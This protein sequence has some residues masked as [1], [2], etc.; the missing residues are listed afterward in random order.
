MKNILI[1]TKKELRS[2]FNNPTA[3]VVV[4]AFLLLWEFLFFRNVFLIG[5]VSLDELFQYLPW[6]FMVVVS[7]LTM[8]TFSEEKKEG[9]LEF[10]LTHPV[11]RAE[12][13]IGKFL[14]IIAFEAAALLFVFP[15]AWSFSLFGELDWGKV[16]GQYL[17][18][19]FIGSVLTS[20]GIF[21]ST[22]FLSQISSFLVSLIGGFF[23]IIVGTNFFSSHFPLEITPF[24]EQL[25]ALNHFNSISRGVVDAR[26]VWYFISLTAVFL[27][28][29]YL[30]LIKEK[31]GNRKSAYINYQVGLI[32]M[33]G[34]FVLSNV[35]G[36][37]I[38]GRIDL[39]KEKIYTL[40]SVTKDIVSNL[41]DLVN[42]SLYASDKLPAQ[43]QPV[44]RETKNILDDYRRFSKG[45]IKIYY[46]NPSADNEIAK[47]AISQGIQPVRFNVVS[48]EEFQVKDGYLGL[49]VSYG[50]RSE[51]I[52]FVEN[53]NDLEYQL[54]SLIYKLTIENKPKIGLVS[55]HGEKSFYGDYRVINDELKKQFETV[56]VMAKGEEKKNEEGKSSGKSDDSDKAVKKI[57][58]PDD[59]K[60]LIIAN[61]SQDYSDEER[62]TISQFI[63]KGGNV[64]FLLD[65]VSVLPQVL[66]ASENQNNLFDFVKSQ[67]GVEVEKNL[68]YDLR[69]NESVS[70]GDGQMRYILPYPFWLRAL[71]ATDNSPIVSKIDSVTLPWASSLN[72]DKKAADE[73]GFDVTELLSTTQYAGTQSSIFDITPD[74]KLSSENLG[75]KVLAVALASRQNGGKIII[76]GDADFLDSENVKNNPSNFS[77][78]VEAVSWLGQ[79][80]RL[81]Q[82]K[83]K[84]LSIRKFVF[85][86]SQD[87]VL[88]KFGNMS[89]VLVT[90]SGYGFWRLY[91][92]RKIKYETYPY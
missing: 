31:Y 4:L 76:V 58:I 8:G 45:K 91:R 39:T 74:K 32:I 23:L 54:S 68:V 90:V 15:L 51:V 37:K 67:T 87:P 81:S 26:D 18:S 10:L 5:E 86:S 85:K 42:I 6:I 75:K 35:V 41:P 79:G 16:V 69:S 50:G 7:A 92:R 60:T 64:L 78:G 44:L 43:L 59:V 29:T 65:G 36:T 2:F 14:G 88:I 89:F 3:Y 9:T 27:G 20:L 53:F 77:F 33:L 30:M 12:L 55:G 62:N 11:S 82:I 22:L 63:S 70:F 28:F 56:D 66:S 57:S 19:A 84:D 46:K 61:P 48:Q 71:K 13:V 21:V 40:S 73:K 80:P 1:I 49:A 24:F 47:E 38:P 17:G 25:S 52:P 72:I 83:I 34:I